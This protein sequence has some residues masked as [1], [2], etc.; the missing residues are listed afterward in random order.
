[1]ARDLV[2]RVTGRRLA[3]TVGRRVPG[4]GGVIGM[5]SDGWATHKIGSYADRELLPRAKR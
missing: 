3:S 5:G 1:M 2:A 4:L